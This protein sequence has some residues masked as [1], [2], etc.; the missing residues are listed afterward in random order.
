MSSS[1]DG[2]A[3]LSDFA[4]SPSSYSFGDFSINKLPKGTARDFITEHHYAGGCGNAIMAWGL[5]HTPTSEL[6]GVIAFQTPI[7]E[8]TRASIFED[9]DGPASKNLDEC[10]CSH[11]S[12]RHGYREHVTELHRMAIVDHAPHNTAT[13][14][15]SR[16]LDRLK[17]H[18]PKYWAVISMADTT[19]D[20]DGTVYQ[21]ANADYYGTSSA[22]TFYEDESGRL[23]N[24]RQ[25]GKNITRAEA[26]KRGW[27][28][29]KRDTK[30]R[31]VFWLPDPYQSK[32]ELREL[33]EIDLQPYPEND[34]DE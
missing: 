34:N 28:P 21:A 6:L 9:I 11:I 26:S 17:D 27:E 15:I 22:R 3:H 13:W 25:C 20:H 12:D 31:Y 32:E 14:F 33:A 29:V 30:H 10:G 5:H 18:K 8:N 16:A 4:P 23:R 7:S 19:E 2:Q 24:P 1:T